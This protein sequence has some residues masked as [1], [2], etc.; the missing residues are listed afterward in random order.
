MSPRRDRMLKHIGRHIGPAVL[1][2]A[3]TLFA[4]VPCLAQGG[5]G[6]AQA[7]D[8][9]GIGS[10][11]PKAIPLKVWTDNPEGTPVK[12]GDAIVVHLQTGEKAYLTAIY[13]SGAGNAIILIPNAQAP[14]SLLLPNT[15]YT[16]FGEDS[17]LKLTVDKKMKEGKIVFYVSPVPFSLGEFKLEPGKACVMMAP[18]AK[19]RLD[20]LQSKIEAMAK[21]EGFNRTVLSLKANG[22]KG[23]SLNLM[24]I[25]AAIKSETPETM[26]GVQGVKPREVPK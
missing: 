19:D 9:S 7:T 21:D 3:I 1:V 25:P 20:L 10:I 24:G 4:A 18:D 26:T 2:I 13:L 17:H 15:E 23:M 22:E 8:L 12:P 11:G 6:P 5:Q 14:E 16:L